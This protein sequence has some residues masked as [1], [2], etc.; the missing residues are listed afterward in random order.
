MNNKSNNVAWQIG[1]MFIALGMVYLVHKQY[2]AWAAG[3]AMY[4]ISRI[5]THL[6]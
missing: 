6:N 1:D 3:M 2:Y 4:W 5:E